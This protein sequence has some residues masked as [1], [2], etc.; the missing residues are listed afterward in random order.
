MK[1][2]KSTQEPPPLKHPKKRPKL[3]NYGLFQTEEDEVIVDSNTFIRPDPLPELFNQWRN[4]LIRDSFTDLKVI[5]ENDYGGL[6]L[7][8][9]I[10][11]SCSTFMASILCDGRDETTLLLPEVDREDFHNLVRNLYGETGVKRPSLELL[12]LLRIT[13]LPDE[14][15]QTT[16]ANERTTS[17]CKSIFLYFLYL[18]YFLNIILDVPNY[19]EST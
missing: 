4:F 8:K 11:A 16:I 3:Q 2:G 17:T 7:H 15:T 19:L 12:T 13:K 10:L 6:S 14:F 9:A 5:C 18:N 1:R